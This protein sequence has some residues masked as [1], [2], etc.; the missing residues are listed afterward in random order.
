MG[1]L[2]PGHVMVYQ[3]SLDPIFIVTSYIK[4]VKTSIV[5]FFNM[6]IKLLCVQ[7]VVNHFKYVV[8]YQIRWVPTSWTHSIIEFYIIVCIWVI[9]EG[10]NRIYLF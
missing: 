5:Y 2:L 6:K 7:E 3:R 4:W 8:K 10:R 1:Q 9:L